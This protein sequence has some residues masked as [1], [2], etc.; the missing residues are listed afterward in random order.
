MSE[1]SASGGRGPAGGDG[2]SRAA[3]AVVFEEPERLS[4]QRVPLAEPTA[5]DVVV[6]VEHSGI[7]T[8]TERLLWKGAMP[9]FPG[10]GYP[11]V[12]GYESVG[13]VVEAGPES[14]R[15]AG[16]LVFVPGARCYTGELRGLFGGAASRLVAS[17]SRVVPLPEA[18]GEHGVLMALAATA[19]H[20]V[21]EAPPE[22]IVGHGVLG[23]LMARIGVLLG[24][25]PT[26]WE[27][28][29]RRRDGALGYPVVDPEADERRDYA[30]ICDVSGDAGLLDTLIG[31][32]AHGGEIVL[33]GFYSERLGFDF[34]GAFMREARLRVAAE[35]RR[36]DLEG[37]LERIAA[38]ELT[39]DGLITHRHGADDAAAAYRTAFSDPACLKMV[40][41]WR[42]GS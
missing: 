1:P 2:A 19:W 30:R 36:A 39:L 12:P 6:D 7:S 10:L 23:R 29:E 34:P 28:D 4:L 17:G 15:R 32:L 16:E 27:R 24:T 31:R 33:A 14:G 26:V 20:A 42:D 21:A 18:L 37:A 8:G 3:R 5:E 35:W 38:G 41:D 40:L 11:L 9:Y 13:R 22:L 25:P